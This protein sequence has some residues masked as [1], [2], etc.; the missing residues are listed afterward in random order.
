MVRAQ[1]PRSRRGHQGDYRRRLENH[2][3]PFLE[4]TPLHQIKVDTIDRYKAAKLTEGL[5]PRSINMHLTILAAI[6]ES[7]VERELIAANPAKG[8]RRRV[9]ERKPQRSYL[10][11][12]RGRYR[13]CSTPRAPSIARHPRS[14]N[15]STA[16]RC[17]RR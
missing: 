9:K 5:S 7:A 11:T 13:R 3:I 12:P 2:L 4:E 8:K 10:G 16:R 15:T 1:A 14:A 17:L 6:L